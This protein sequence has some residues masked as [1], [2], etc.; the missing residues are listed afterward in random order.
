M[1]L[2]I[3]RSC[4]CGEHEAHVMNRDNILPA[5]I[6]VNLYCPKCRHLAVWNPDTMIEDKGWILEYDLEA[7]QFFFWRRRGIQP[8][9]PEFL[10]DEGYCSWHGLTPL[11]LDESARIHR[12]LAPLL[13]QDRL[14]Y[15]NRLKELWIDYVAHLKADGWRKAQRT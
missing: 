15:I 5:E 14:V 2:S 1:C 6:L 13:A 10:F 8:I 12:E 9:T 4:V 7:A 3:K 11:D